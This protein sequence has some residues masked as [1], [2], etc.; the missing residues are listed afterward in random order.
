VEEAYLQAQRLSVGI[1]CGQEGRRPTSALFIAF[2]TENENENV[3]MKKYG[4][5][6]SFLL[7]GRILLLKAG[8]K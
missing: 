1:L 7:N 2:E 8:N 3:N 4:N 6:S 5:F